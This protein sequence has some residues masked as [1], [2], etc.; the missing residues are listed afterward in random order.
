MSGLARGAFLFGSHCLQSIVIAF[1]AIFTAIGRFFDV[2]NSIRSDEDFEEKQ[3][4]LP[5]GTF[6]A[7]NKLRDRGFDLY[8]L[9]HLEEECM[10]MPNPVDAAPV[11]HNINIQKTGLERPGIA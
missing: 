8:E 1:L 4:Q 5:I 10:S 11:S 9:D 7:S 2:W 6:V 3:R